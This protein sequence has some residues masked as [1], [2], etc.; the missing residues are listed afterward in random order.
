MR[1]EN[2]TVDLDDPPPVEHI[3][4]STDRT[5]SRSRLCK[6]WLRILQR[7]SKSRHSPH[8]ES[9]G[10]APNLGAALRCAF[11]FPAC[12]ICSQESACEFAKIADLAYGHRITC[13]NA[14]TRIIFSVLCLKFLQFR[15]EPLDIGLFCNELTR[16]LV[17][18]M[19]EFVLSF[20]CQLLTY[21]VACQLQDL[22]VSVLP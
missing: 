14:K 8:R 12:T 21:D 19:C 2:N 3:F 4:V 17:F 11:A 15:F 10:P 7:T 5:S 6:E 22:P 9:G 18:C 13:L 20:F 16:D 1:R